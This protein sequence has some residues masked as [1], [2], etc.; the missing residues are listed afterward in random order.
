MASGNKLVQ[1]HAGGLETKIDYNT[2]HIKRKPKTLA[3]NKKL[4]KKI[5]RAKMKKE[6]S[7][8]INKVLS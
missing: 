1:I 5:V 4:G 8:E 3:K 7:N 6:V 2:Y